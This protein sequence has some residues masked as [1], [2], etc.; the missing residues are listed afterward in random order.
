MQVKVKMFWV[1]IKLTV[2]NN[3]QFFSNRFPR[4]AK[5]SVFVPASVRPFTLAPFCKKKWTMSVWL[6]SAA[7][8][9]AVQPSKSRLSTGNPAFSISTTSLTAPRL[10]SSVKCL[11]SVGL[12]YM[13]EM[14]IIIKVWFLRNL[15]LMCYVMLCYVM[16]ILFWFSSTLALQWSNLITSK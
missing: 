5:C 10:A 13:K 7:R 8:M 2:L 15:W 11:M 16:S 1:Q 12:I 14:N 3:I 4:E 9:S 6:F